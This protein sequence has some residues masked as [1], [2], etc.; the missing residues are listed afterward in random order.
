VRGR[1][2]LNVRG[3]RVIISFEIRQPQPSQQR[4][5]KNFVTKIL[6]GD[7]K[8]FKQRSE[9]EEIIQKTPDLTGR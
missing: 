8:E 1:P 6:Y 5:H 3:Y 7:K 2:R 4:Q 9:T